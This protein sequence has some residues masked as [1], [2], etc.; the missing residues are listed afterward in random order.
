M[1]F[2][3][4]EIS[5]RI[6]VGDGGVIEDESLLDIIDSYL[7]TE[8]QTINRMKEHFKEFPFMTQHSEHHMVVIFRLEK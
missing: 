8:A 4:T 1:A 7:R 3:A 6:K 5:I 2:N